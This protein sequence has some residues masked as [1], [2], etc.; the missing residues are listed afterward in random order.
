[1]TPAVKPRRKTCTRTCKTS[2]VCVLWV[3]PTPLLGV[4][5]Q[6]VTNEEMVQSTRA[7]PGFCNFRRDLTT[8]VR[9]QHTAVGAATIDK[10]RDR[11][12]WSGCAQE[13]TLLHGGNGTWCSP[14]QQR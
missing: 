10:S 13:G 2:G 1:M 14:H 12:C 5:P 8:T 3:A 11:N 4:T 9:H 6:P 7:S